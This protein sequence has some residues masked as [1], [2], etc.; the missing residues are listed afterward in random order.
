MEILRE[1]NATGARKVP[2]TAPVS[3]V[4]ARWR[5]YLDTAAKVGNTSAYRHY[6]E[7]CTLLALR[8]GLRTGDVF[9]P[10][11]APLLRPCRLPAHPKLDL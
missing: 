1:L 5:G 11:L 3:F 6:W 8:D 10:G 2:D 7:L 4:P 9:V